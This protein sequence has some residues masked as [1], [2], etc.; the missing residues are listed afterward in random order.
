MC[1]MGRGVGVTAAALRV[2]SGIGYACG[3]RGPPG[4]G[5]PLGGLRAGDGGGVRVRWGTTR[6]GVKSYERRGR[7]P[8]FSCFHSD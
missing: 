1:G 5:E 6:E 8:S 7:P 3:H 2:A 4:A